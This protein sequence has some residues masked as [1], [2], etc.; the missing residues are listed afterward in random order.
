MSLMSLTRRAVLGMAVATLLPGGIA[1]AETTEVT[2]V[3]VN[4]SDKM[5]PDDDGRGGFAKMASVFKKERGDNPNTVVVHAGDMLSPSL[6]SGFDK[7]EH[8]IELAN[9]AGFDVAAP[10][11]HEYDFG[12]ENAMSQ[13]SKA[14]FPFLAANIENADGTPFEDFEPTMM[15]EFGPVKVGFIGLAELTTGELSSPGDEIT[16]TDPVAAAEKQAET[17]RSQGADFVV[18]ISHNALPLNEQMVREG[19]VDLVLSGHNH[20]VWSY[21][22]G[23]SA[24][25]ESGH[26]AMWIGTVDV[27]FDVTEE[28]GTR[29]VDWTPSFRFTDTMDVEPDADVAAKVAEYE[30]TLDKELDVDVGTTSVELDSRRASVRSQETIMGSLIADAMKKATGADI[31]ITNGGGIRGDKTY[32]AGSTLTRRDVLS[33][34]PFGNRTVLLEMTGAQVKE[35]LENGVGQIEEGAGRFPQVSGLTF[36]VDSSAEAGARISDVKVDGKDL[37]ESANYK[38]ATN[39]YMAGGGDGY[40]VMSEGKVLVDSISGKL[41]ANDVMVYI[42]EIGD[43]KAPEGTRIT[44]N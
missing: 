38:V 10:G 44:I 41:M 5:A 29:E 19:T 39:D 42:R 4:D 15:K 6:L 27:T 31:A 25:L 32:P 16:F 22:N 8:I 35:A 26:D 14:D 20:V 21:Y 34:L 9:M 7:G 40:S 37:D 1:L 28:E 30:A 17:L 18:A 23:R 2:F 43:V 24:G 3:L 36:S 12:S 33:E 11:N 13:L